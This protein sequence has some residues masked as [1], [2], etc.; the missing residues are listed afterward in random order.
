MRLYLLAF[1]ALF[2]MNAMA[3]DNWKAFPYDQSA[4]DYPGDKLK[5]AWPRL[6]RG[7]GDY[8]YPDADW[9]VNMATAHPDALEKTV[10]AGTGFTGKP[11]EAAQYA[12][13]LQDVW[14]LLFRGDYAKAKEQGLALGVGGQVPA[15]FAQVLYAMFLAPDQAE[16]QRLF[17][18][19]DN[20]LGE[21]RERYQ[22]LIAKPDD[23]EDILLAGAAKARRIATPFIAELREAV[24]LRSLREPLKSAESGKKK[25]AK[26]ARLVSFRD[27]DGSFRFRLL[28]A[29]GEQLLLSRAFADGKAAGAVSKRLLA[30]ETADLRAEGNAFGLWLDGEAVAQSPAFADAAARDA[31]IERT[32]EALAPQE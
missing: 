20:E 32:R 31:A 6:T 21:A 23:I 10:K 25:A 26:A 14:R 30:G 28:D 19:L 5:E 11:E 3:A 18:L 15:M 2:G 8:P 24:G 7:F 27:D 13:R 4:Y 22:A 1:L 29:A 16:K 9:V 17:Q 12:A